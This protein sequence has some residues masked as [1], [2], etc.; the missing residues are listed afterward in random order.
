MACLE[1]GDRNTGKHVRR[2]MSENENVR[3]TDLDIQKRLATSGLTS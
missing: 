2:E 3:N 1:N